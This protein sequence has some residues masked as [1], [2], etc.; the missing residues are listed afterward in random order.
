MIRKWY[1][2]LFLLV[3]YVG[4]FLLWKH[5]PSRPAFF[6]GGLTAV[7]LLTIGLVV[8]W[9]NGYFAGRVDACLHAYVIVDLILES[10][11]FEVFRSIVLHGNGLVSQFHNNNNFVGCTLTLTALVGGYRWWALRGSV[12]GGKKKSIDE[13]LVDTLAESDSVMAQV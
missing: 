12:K 6:A 4:V 5:F 11:S 8:A 9:R 2:S 3:L 10:V 1:Y 7:A 13:R